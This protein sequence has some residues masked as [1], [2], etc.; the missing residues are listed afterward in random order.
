M[1]HNRIA[2]TLAAS[3]SLSANGALSPPTMPISD[4]DSRGS[5]S[6]ILQQAESVKA[7]LRQAHTEVAGLVS[8]LKRYRQQSKFMQAT[9]ASLKQLQSLDV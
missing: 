8:R 2:R 9:L 4:H 6:T 3:A 7:T 5:F 1:P